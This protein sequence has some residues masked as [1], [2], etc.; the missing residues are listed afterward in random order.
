MLSLSFLSA[1]AWKNRARETHNTGVSIVSID[2][3]YEASLEADIAWNRELRRLWG[4]DAGRA[5]S[6]E[7][8]VSTLHL[9]EVQE[10][11]AVANEAYMAALVADREPLRRAVSGDGGPA[12]RK[13]APC[14]I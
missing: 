1:L 3:L 2:D 10:K 8:G 13:G 14:R 9:R 5:R 7:R 12:A 6:D 4:R 11:Y